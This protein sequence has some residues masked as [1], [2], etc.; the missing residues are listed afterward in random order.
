MEKSIQYTMHRIATFF[1]MG[2]F[3][4]GGAFWQTVSSEVFISP[5]YAEDEDEDEEEEEED[6]DEGE[7]EDEYEDA[8]K[9]SKTKNVPIYETVLVTKTITTLDPI[10]MTDQDGDLLVDG[11]DPHPTVHEREYFTDDDGDS[12][13]NAFDMHPGDDD[14]SYYEGENDENR[15]GILDSYEPLEER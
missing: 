6:E 8:S 4:A 5:V 9:S 11:L 14:F 7:D 3:V 12:A 15:N 1:L 13:P 2:I 10:F